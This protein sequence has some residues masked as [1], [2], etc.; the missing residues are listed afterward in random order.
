MSCTGDNLGSQEYNE[1]IMSH[2]LDCVVLKS[3]DV[4]HDVQ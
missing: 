2:M 4:S 3:H 1:N